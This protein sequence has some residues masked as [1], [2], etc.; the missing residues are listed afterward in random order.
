MSPFGKI[1]INTETRVLYYAR[2]TQQ[3]SHSR[4]T[5]TLTSGPRKHDYA[6]LEAVSQQTHLG[7]RGGWGPSLIRDGGSEQLCLGNSPLMQGLG[8]LAWETRS[9][10]DLVSHRSRT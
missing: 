4:Q 5:T 7:R 1:K 2:P 9:T 10:N 3:H 6:V 8:L